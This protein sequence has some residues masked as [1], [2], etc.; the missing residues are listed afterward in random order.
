MPS[1]SK[2]RPSAH[3][4]NPYSNP[5][6]PNH[7][8]APAPALA[9]A[10]PSQTLN[11]TPAQ[12]RP[13]SPR[14]SFDYLAEARTA[15]GRDPVTGKRIQHQRSHN[16]LAQRRRVQ[17][18]ERAQT[19]TQ[20]RSLS[21]V[22]EGSRRGG[23]GEDRSAFADRNEGVRRTLGTRYDLFVQEMKERRLGGIREPSGGYYAP[24]R[25]VEEFYG[26]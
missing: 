21:A 18:Q 10:T 23:N 11:T 16:E 17:E 8:P 26:R 2:L 5:N 3:K 4:G 1:F 9:P 22:A 24:E 12:H 13:A 7:N 25:R 15:V 6:H 20:S 19:Q 14:G